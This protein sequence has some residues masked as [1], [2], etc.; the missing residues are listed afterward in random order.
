MR[1]IMCIVALAG[2]G[3]GGF[4]LAATT[5]V[6][7]GPTGPQPATVTVGWGDTVAF[8]NGDSA[9][10]VVTIPRLEA[11][12]PALDPGAT[13]T[14]VFDG[15]GGNYVF[16][17]IGRPSYGGMVVVEVKGRVTLT[18]PTPAIEYGRS[19]TLRGTSSIV[20]TPVSI[21]QR[22]PGESA[23]FTEAAKVQADASGSFSAR[24]RPRGPVYYRATIAAGQLRSPSV[25]IA[26]RPR[27]KASASPRSAPV[28]RRVTITVRVT[29]AGSAGRADLER[30]DTRRKDWARED[31]ARVARSGRAVFAWKTLKGSTRLRVRLRRSELRP[32]WAEASSPAFVV[33][34]R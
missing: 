24:L 5:T 30:Y 7:L 34:G 32:G 11:A 15:R 20:N 33:T 4:A 31:Q 17:Q 26:V 3:V 10:H 25:Q 29:P 27:V 19:V 23:D 9:S 16:R 14:Q 12:S 13:Y 8:V 1:K 18:T 28:G 22:E 21:V 6:T 2:L